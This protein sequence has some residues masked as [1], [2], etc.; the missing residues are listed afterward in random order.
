MVPYMRQQE[1][2]TCNTGGLIKKYINSFR[3]KHLRIVLWYVSHRREVLH[4]FKFSLTKNVK[5]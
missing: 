1:K 5:R 2:I 4:K 3:V